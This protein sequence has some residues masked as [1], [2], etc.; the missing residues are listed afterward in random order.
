MKV[1]IQQ[2]PIEDGIRLV[3]LADGVECG[4]LTAFPLKVKVGSRIH[5]VWAGREFEVDEKWRSTRLGLLLPEALWQESPEHFAICAATSAQA[6][7]VYE[8]LGYS[9]FD[10]PQY[11][12]MWKSQ[13]LLR[14]QRTQLGC[15]RWIAAKLLDAAIAVYASMLRIVSAW[16]LR[17]W[18]FQTTGTTGVSPVEN[19]G[20]TG[21]PPVENT[22]TTGVP[23]VESAAAI[24][25][26]DPRPCAEVHDA[27]WFRWA[28]EKGD[29][30][31]TLVTDQSHHPVAFWLTKRRVHASFSQG[32]YREVAMGHVIE[33]GVVPEFANREP[34]LVIR[35]A[36]GLRSDCD[37]VLTAT[38]GGEVERLMR[39]LRWRASGCGNFVVRASDAVAPIW[40]Q[41]VNWRLR[42]AMAD[43][44]LV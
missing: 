35:A 41:S 23:P 32:R 15:L 14:G 11:A 10:L 18:K 3:G 43:Y 16:K 8:F 17:G 1:E 6:R 24:A 5:Q 7:P 28:I 42:G 2:R 12:V 4:G 39:R 26:L 31:L 25:A 36:L 40:T 34:W 19:T 38:E 33:W 21:V 37:L 20:T 44:V 22:G 13:W 30:R 29:C 9:T 27:A